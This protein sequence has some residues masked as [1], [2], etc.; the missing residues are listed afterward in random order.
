MSEAA[1]D[2]AALDALEAEATRPPWSATGIELSAPSEPDG[3]THEQLE[4]NATFIAAL[5][6]AYPSLREAILAL[7]ERVTELE[8]AHNERNARVHA[9][10]LVQATSEP[11]RDKLIHELDSALGGD[12]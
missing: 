2:L 4:K 6:N 10:A 7:Q 12:R 3:P 8:V 1:F 11:Q 9:L 5:R